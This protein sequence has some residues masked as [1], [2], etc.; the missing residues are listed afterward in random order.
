[1]C[2]TI[3][4]NKYTATNSLDQRQDQDLF[5]SLFIRKEENNQK[6]YIIAQ[7]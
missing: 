1:M 7:K 2:I 5:Q 4:E 6:K 3:I